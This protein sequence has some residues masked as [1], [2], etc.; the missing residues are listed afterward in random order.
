MLTA[1]GFWFFF[2]VSSMVALA[3]IMRAPTLILVGLTLLGW[4]L[5]QWFLFQMRVRLSVRRLSVER[6]LRTSRGEVASIWAKQPVEVAIRVC[7]DS[8][9]G[10]P[11]V[12]ASERVPALARVKEGAVQW[13]GAL[14]AAA[15]LAWEYTIICKAPGRLRF[16]GVKIEIA[17]LQGFFTSA[18]FIR[19]AKEY[20]VLPA[21]V[22]EAAQTPFVKQIN[23]LPLLGSHRHA[24]PGG[25]SELLDLRDYQTGDPPKLIAWKIS[26]RRDRLI[27]KE[28][29]SEVPIRCT[30]FLDTS[31]SVRV[32]PAGETAL[33]RLIEIAAGLAQAND[34]ER[35]LTG[36][37][38]FDE[39]GVGAWIK[40]GRGSKHMVKLLDH[41]THAAG[42]IPHKP[43]ATVR[44][45]LP[46]AFG[47]AQDVYPEYLDRDAN[48]FP[49][50]LALWA[51]Q[52]G[53][54][55]PPGAPRYWTR[56][57][58]SM[59]RAQ[60][61]RKL[62]AAILAVRYELG[63]GGVGLLMEDDLTCAEFLQRFLAE[64]Q[65]ACPFARYDD[66]GVNAFAAPAKV[67]V[68]ADAL[69]KS[70]THGKDNEL[71]VLCVDL[72]DC[73][74]S[75]PALE[76]AVCVARARH[77]QVLVVAPWPNDV[78]SP[79]RIVALPRFDAL[80]VHDVM[81][82]VFADR[83]QRA[84]TRFRRSFGKLGVPVL[85]A[86]QHDSVNAILHRMRRLRIQERGVR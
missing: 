7:C 81:R 45:L 33:C 83:M 73:E 54:T 1:R 34:S 8:A 80:E 23:T 62:L 2:S 65:V 3:I 32:G 76:R 48:D 30:V 64:H 14:T 26:A 84:F 50:W 4:F 18:T 6:T 13:D 25:S 63:P 70:V 24:R 72:F 59:C 68:F 19:A 49:W 71:F 21:L 66:H 16:E 37:C 11:Y 51:P 29:E 20:R 69:V 41:L 43:R 56:F 5:S 31:N 53:W 38:L 35:D 78:A 77:H 55:I 28:F 15:P 61:W 17:D 82:Y 46:F 57:S 36:L 58:P 85:C 42:F 22:V 79:D 12:I 27:T 47:L 10:L 40:P 60:R 74:E 44:E 86:A 9:A 39:T 52:P 75:L 67:Q